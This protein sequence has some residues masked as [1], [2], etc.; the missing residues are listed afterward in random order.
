L[1]TSNYTTTGV[2]TITLSASQLVDDSS[3]PGAGSNNDGTVAVTLQGNV[4]NATADA[5]NSQT[6][7]GPAL[8]SGVLVSVTTANH[9]I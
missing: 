4:G 8:T 5:D 6:A 7:F 1:S 2:T 3:L 9:P